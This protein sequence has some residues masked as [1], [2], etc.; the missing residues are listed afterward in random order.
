MTTAQNKKWQKE[1]VA[2]NRKRKGKYA[3]IYSTVNGVRIYKKLW[4]TKE[5]IV[6][7]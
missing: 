1:G 6:L 2:M 4:L 5:D 3:I 7:S